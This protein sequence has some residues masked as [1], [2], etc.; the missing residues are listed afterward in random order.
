MIRK[1]LQIWRV[2][3]LRKKILMVLFLLAVTRVL[4]AIPI[5]GVNVAALQQFFN[6]NQLFGL[7]DIFSGGGLSNFSIAMMGVGPYIT[8]SIIMQLLAI[9]IPKLGEMQKEG[10]QGRAKIN[11]YT[12]YMTVPLAVLQGIGTILLF[13]RGGAGGA[14]VLGTLT[15]ADWFVI[16]LSI[17]AGTLILMWLRELFTGYGIGNG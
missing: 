13:T 16:L 5:P 10:E 15:S 1:F 3:D 2:A 12:R 7:L 6:Q 8:A 14:N 4:A 17:T 11:Q 9:I